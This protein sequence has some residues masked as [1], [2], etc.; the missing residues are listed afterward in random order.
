MMAG[1]KKSGADWQVVFEPTG[2]GN[3]ADDLGH[4]DNDYGWPLASTESRSQLFDRVCWSWGRKHMRSQYSWARIP[5]IACDRRQGN[6]DIQI[7]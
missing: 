6:V 2:Q 7:F 3:K 4:L 1:G 5:L